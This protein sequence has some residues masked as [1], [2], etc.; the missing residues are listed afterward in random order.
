MHKETQV[1][2]KFCSWSK[3]LEPIGQDQ[4]SAVMVVSWS[5]SL[6]KPS[7]CQFAKKMLSIKVRLTSS[8][9]KTMT[10]MTLPKQQSGKK[11]QG[12]KVERF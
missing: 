2:G 5:G 7:V 8:C 6:C 10:H 11:H 1:N 12:K 9:S 3:T 4:S